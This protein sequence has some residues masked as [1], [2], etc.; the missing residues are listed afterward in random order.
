MALWVEI[1]TG[2]GVGTF[3]AKVAEDV[4]IVTLGRRS[5]KKSIAKQQAA[6]DKVMRRI[7][8]LAESDPSLYGGEGVNNG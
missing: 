2:V 4:L 3:S 5:R 7:G 8:A 6:Y 1:A